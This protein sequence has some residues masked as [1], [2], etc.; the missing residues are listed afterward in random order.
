[1]YKSILVHV[2]PE[3]PGLVERIQCATRLADDCHAT[4]IGAAAAM[5]AASVELMAAG[6]TALAAGIATGDP[7]E[8]DNYFAAGKAEFARWTKDACVQTEWRT[9]VDFPAPALAT[10]AA[11]ADLLVVGPSHRST[12]A[13]RRLDGADLV[14]RAGRPVLVL[15]DAT[16]LDHRTAVVAWRN[17]RESRRALADALPLLS[18]YGQVNLLHV[19]E[20]SEERDTSIADAQA[21]LAGHTIGATVKVL[22]P[23]RR[24]TTE[25]ILEFAQRAQA[26]LLVAGAYGHT[27]V[28]EWVLGG[29]TRELLAEPP[30]ACFFSR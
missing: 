21:F 7:R 25:R 8:L 3:E 29:V 22:P 23:E 12:P 30:M 9:A 13:N 14:M 24:S 27:R 15:P 26:D 5:P 20:G 6:A 10:M 17:T 28:R 19:Q 16:P 2:D 4:L 18:T 1:M 11:R